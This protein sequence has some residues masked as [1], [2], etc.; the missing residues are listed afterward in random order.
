M[1]HDVMPGGG[2]DKDMLLTEVTSTEI[3]Y[4]QTPFQLQSAIYLA[5]AAATGERSS[6][7]Q[8]L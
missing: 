4:R 2:N 5:V 7:L 6:S 1:I 8:R 3:D